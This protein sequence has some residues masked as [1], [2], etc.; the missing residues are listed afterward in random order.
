MPFISSTRAVARACRRACAPRL[1]GTSAAAVRIGRQAAGGEV[2]FAQMM[3]EHRAAVGRF[4]QILGGQRVD[5]VAVAAPVDERLQPEAAEEL[6]EL[7]RMAERVG[8]VGDASTPDRSAR[9]CGV[10]SSRLRTCASP[11]GSSESGCTYHG[12]MAM[13]P[14]TARCGQRVAPLGADLQVVFEHHRL[15][16]EQEVE[17][18][19][20]RRSA[21]ARDRSCR[22]AARGTPGRC[23]TTRDPSV[24]GRR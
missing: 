6:R 23:D 2:A 1:R 10:P 21:R 13:R 9:R 24:C 14:V 20:A 8:R 3:R 15:P 4:P 11:D 7:R 16:V 5:L 12:P 17:P 19:V 22:P 18:G